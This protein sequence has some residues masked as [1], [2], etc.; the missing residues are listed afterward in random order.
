MVISYLLSWPNLAIANPGPAQASEV[1]S[2]TSSVRLLASGSAFS[3]RCLHS[4]APPVRHAVNSASLTGSLVGNPA[5]VEAERD[6]GWQ[7]DAC[8]RLGR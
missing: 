2:Q 6:P 1:R 7:V 4:T 8:D 3:R 5:A